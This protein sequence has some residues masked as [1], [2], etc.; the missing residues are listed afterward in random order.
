MKKVCTLNRNKGGDLKFD[1]YLF[2]SNKETTSS[3][4][5]IT[6][7]CITIAQKSGSIDKK[8]IEEGDYWA[9]HSFD[10]ALRTALE[11]LK[12]VNTNIPKGVSIGYEPAGSNFTNRGAARG[13]VRASYSIY[14]I[15]KSFDLESLLD[16]KLYE[17][18][19]PYDKGTGWYEDSIEKIDEDDVLYTLK[20]KYGHGDVSNQLQYFRES[21]FYNNPI[22]SDEF[23][24][25]MDEY[26]KSDENNE[27]YAGGGKVTTR[28]G[29]LVRIVT[30]KKMDKDNPSAGFKV[31]IK[32]LEAMVANMANPKPKPK[33]R[34][35]KLGD[36]YSEDFDYTGMLEYGL[37]KPLL[38]VKIEILE[39]LSD[40]FEDVNYHDINKPLQQ[41]ISFLNHGETE[42]AK[43]YLIQFKSACRKGLGIATVYIDKKGNK[44]VVKDSSTKE[45]WANEYFDTIEEAYAF[46][47]QN[48]LDIEPSPEPDTKWIESKEY[49][50]QFT[51]GKDDGE[52]PMFTIDEINL[53]DTGYKIENEYRASRKSQG[54]VEGYMEDG[55]KLTYSNN[56][57]GGSWRI[58]VTIEAEKPKPEPAPKHKVGD[59]LMH[60]DSGKSYKVKILA[61]TGWTG[62]GHRYD[63]EF[64]DENDKGKGTFAKSYDELL[65]EPSPE[66][67]TEAEK[68]TQ[69]MIGQIN[70]PVNVGI[71]SNDN[72]TVR[73][74]WPE[75]SVSVVIDDSD[76][77]VASGILLKYENVER[78][79]TLKKI[80]DAIHDINE[81]IEKPKPGGEEKPK[82]S[83]NIFANP[84]RFIKYGGEFLYPPRAEEKIRPTTFMFS[85]VDNGTFIA[86]PKLNGSATSVTIF[87]DSF[88][89]KERHNTFFSVPPTFDF[90]SLHR[91][92]GAMCLTGEFMNKSK[93]DENGVPLRGFC[94]WDIT[95]YE[96]N[97]LVG[98]TIE[99]RIKLLE[100]LYPSAGV[101]KTKEGTDLLYKTDVPDVYRVAN[102]DKDFDKLFNEISKIDLVEGFVLKRKTGRLEMMT[103]EVQNGGWQIKAR[104]PTANYEHFDGGAIEPKTDLY[105]KRREN[106]EMFL[107]LNDEDIY[108]KWVNG[109][110]TDLMAVK[111]IEEIHSVKF[112]P[113]KKYFDGG[114]TGNK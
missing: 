47:A 53:L 22:D 103:K 31:R 34:K 74:T 39:A 68:L 9:Y 78:N 75:L 27:N 62:D 44:F 19:S 60:E 42:K 30:L 89:A 85:K 97:I 18:G 33:P 65:S 46:I 52:K 69:I 111:L 83:G 72:H 57:F 113:T 55:N 110:L 6:G 88:I 43:Q 45:N 50:G 100:Q 112:N 114:A 79:Y 36:K 64:L 16:D 35:Y 98:S 5:K 92:K 12:A 4:R 106:L 87:E 14:N 10:I 32:T 59:I 107:N 51:D 37:N 48:N 25:Q 13:R 84:E 66:T 96:N 91:G 8:L 101:I 2:S 80:K 1:V 108:W 63:I 7:Y 41:A 86:Q 71:T 104:K 23:A 76:S 81:L 70:S 54:E 73:L 105:W 99:E 56:E 109:E 58:W 29:L 67:E 28:G 94:I 49:P 26:L 77:P 11:E 82:P 40:S 61:I 90:Q 102:F 20:Y 15:Y 3:L 24:E 93:K 17:G 21:S 95:A 38:R